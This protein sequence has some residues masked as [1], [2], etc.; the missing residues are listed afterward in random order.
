[1]NL[2]A[3]WFIQDHYLAIISCVL[4]LAILLSVVLYLVGADWK[5]L[6]SVIGGLLSFV[7]LIQRQQLEEARLIKELISEFNERYD[8][9]N[10]RLNAITSSKPRKIWLDFAER[11]TLYDYFNLCGEEYLYYQKG[12]VYQEVWKA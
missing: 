5:A 12:Y 6:L 11:N 2:K 4:L 9:L 10:E 1:M 7:F 8:G 3:K